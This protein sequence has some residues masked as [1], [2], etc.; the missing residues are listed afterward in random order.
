MTHAVPLEHKEWAWAVEAHAV[1]GTFIFP[2][3][4]KCLLH[5]EG[6][7]QLTDADRIRLAAVDELL[8]L[9]DWGSTKSYEPSNWCNVFQDMKQRRIREQMLV[10]LRELQAE[11]QPIIP[12][13]DET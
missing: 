4:V 8:F 7:Y 2:L 3:T 5:R 10:R 12:D 13:W 11:G 1:L 9:D 6:F